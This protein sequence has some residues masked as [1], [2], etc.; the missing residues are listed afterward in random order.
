MPTAREIKKDLELSISYPKKEYRRD[1]IAVDDMDAI[2]G[3]GVDAVDE[4][5][6][7]NIG[8]ALIEVCRMGIFFTE[9]QDEE[10]DAAEVVSTISNEFRKTLATFMAEKCKCESFIGEF[11]VMDGE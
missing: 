3:A 8:Q 4:V 5:G 1:R 6:K 9:L 2:L 11:Q 7:C 10:S